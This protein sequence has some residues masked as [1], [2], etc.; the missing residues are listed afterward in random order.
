MNGIQAF[1]KLQKGNT[2]YCRGEMKCLDHLSLERELTAKNGQQPFAIIFTCSDA[3]VIPEFVFDQGIGS[4]FVVREIGHALSEASL[5]SIEYGV[6]HLGIPLLVVLGHTGCGAVKADLHGQQADGALG[7]TLENLK[8][9]I[10]EEED[11]LKA[12][13]ANVSATVEQLRNIFKTEVEIHGA[14]LN[15]ET[16]FVE[17][18]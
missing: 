7:R 15:L 17:M 12:V 8:S 6:K 14:I 4:L 13:S 18:D 11:E 5:A 10:G 9:R 1:T 2:R 3:R 16:G